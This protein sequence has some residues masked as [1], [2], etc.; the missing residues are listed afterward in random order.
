MKTYYH[1]I[2]MG[3][4]GGLDLTK[5][6]IIVHV[7]GAQSVLCAW[8]LEEVPSWGMA[9]QGL[10]TAKLIGT[11]EFFQGTRINEVKNYKAH[12]SPWSSGANRFDLL[13]FLKSQCQWLTEFWFVLTN[14]SKRKKQNKSKTKEQK[15]DGYLGHSLKFSR[16]ECIFVQ[17]LEQ[18][19]CPNVTVS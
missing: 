2:C 10:G 6:I 7:T 12:I 14:A 18:L 13:V 8:L 9:R 4:A 11:A 16:S 15:R 3:A 1:I 19:H 17:W 5:L